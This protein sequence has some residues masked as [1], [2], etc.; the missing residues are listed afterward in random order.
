MS[1]DSE[2]LQRYRKAYKA[3][4]AARRSALDE[5]RRAMREGAQRAADM[6]RRDFAATR[7][8]L[9]GSVLREEGFHRGSDLDLAVE[10]IEADR[11]WSAGAAAERCAG[12]ELDLVDLEYASAGLREHIENEGIEL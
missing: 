7:V 8:L 12:Y 1:T 4:E 11:F 9:F 10:G 2:S 3:R 5:R 6:L